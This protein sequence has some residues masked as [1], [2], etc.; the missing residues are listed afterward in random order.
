MTVLIFDGS[1]L[2]QR[3]KFVAV[4]ENRISSKYMSWLLFR[5]LI[6]K[7]VENQ[8]SR[9]YVLWDEGACTY[10]H[11]IVEGYKE[12]RINNNPS[13]KDVL[14]FREFLDSRRYLHEIL[15]TIGVVSIKVPGV[16]ADD[17]GHYLSNKFDTGVLVSEDKDWLLNLRPGWKLI[18]PIIKE[19]YTWESFDEMMNERYYKNP[20]EYTHYDPLKK[21]LIM[22]A[23][24]GDK[25]EVPRITT[26]APAKKII[27]YL[28]GQIKSLDPKEKS[29][30]DNS[31]KEL[32][33][34]LRLAATDW[35]T[36]HP[37]LIDSEG[38]HQSELN[39]VTYK[40]KENFL[41]V[42]SELNL[43]QYINK[44]HKISE[45]LS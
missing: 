4:K 25:D 28:T 40:S 33:R 14:A 45:R 44:W 31:R 30:L 27:D 38:I 34:N 23:V 42:A 11:K 20:T 12:S 24:Y 18:R 43:F 6:K 13:E 32:A 17:W 35:L 41:K 19:E 7:C 39:R 5:S 26:P 10:R 16:E 37:E 22:K 8:P 2:L 21:Y 36:V 29:T 15:P 9:I 1:H 3:M